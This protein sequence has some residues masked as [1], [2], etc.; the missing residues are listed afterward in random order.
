MV[1]PSASAASKGFNSTAATPLPPTVP[2]ASASN[3]RHTPVR[4]RI[5]PSWYR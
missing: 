2:S 4:D 3:A 5:E 1:S